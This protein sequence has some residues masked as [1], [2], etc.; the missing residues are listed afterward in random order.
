MAREPRPRGARTPRS[1]SP[2]EIQET[3]APTGTTPPPGGGTGA[4]RDRAIDALLRLATERRWD[5]I[6]ITDV[7][8]EAGLS[9]SEFR[10]LFPSKG[11]ILGAYSRRIDKIVLD[12]TTDDLEGESVRE[13]LFDVLM[14]RLDAMSADKAALRAIARDLRQDPA[15]LA[16][17]NQVA[18]NSQRFMLAAAG[19]G[20]EG[21]LG[22]IKL[23][24]AVLLF[25]R[26]L[27]AWFSDDDPG[28]SRTM[29][30]LDR[31]LDRAGRTIGML[32]DACRI[33]A[34]FRA[35]FQR[36]AEGPRRFRERARRDRDEPRYDDDPDE[37][38]AP[39][40]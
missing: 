38:Y 8:R 6:E 22:A 14:R 16:A 35:L 21:P 7:A 31:E 39:A 17:L 24:G 33:A 10:D 36:V 3:T 23:Q 27:D 2:E 26:V 1:T 34:P 28:L 18:L 40:M 37:D 4:P 25:A 5:D 19:I 29:A 9:L 11:A 20:T 12:G 30:T 15:S 32:S 13:R